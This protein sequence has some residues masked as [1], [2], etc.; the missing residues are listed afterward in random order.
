MAMPAAPEISPPRKEIR[1][2]RTT[3]TALV[4]CLALSTA[5]LLA[6][7]GH[8][9]QPRPAAVK[10]SAPAGAIHQLWGHLVAL[11]SAA[12]C[13]GDPDGARCAA[14]AA[15]PTLPPEGCIID[16]NGACAAGTSTP[17]PQPAPEG[18]IGDPNGLCAS[19]W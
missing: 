19:S 5:P 15:N 3:R 4:L 14:A 16:P 17:I 10:P 2:P 12:G 7:P 8:Q 6:A 13:I 11:W 1:M 9:A 18:C